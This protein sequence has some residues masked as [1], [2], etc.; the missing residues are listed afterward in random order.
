MLHSDI[1]HLNLWY[2]DQG[3]FRKLLHPCAQRSIPRVAHVPESSQPATT[4]S[5]NHKR[6]CVIAG[7]A[8]VRQK[9]NFITG[10]L[11]AH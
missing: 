10:N 9:V 1:S 5:A 7:N 6:E 4:H 2:S 11:E 3:L 8:S